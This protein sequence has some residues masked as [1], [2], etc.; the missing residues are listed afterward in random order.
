MEYKAHR[1]SIKVLERI[2][3]GYTVEDSK[4]SCDNDGIDVVVY[5]EKEKRIRID[6]WYDYGGEI[7]ENLDMSVKEFCDALGIVPEDILSDKEK[8][9]F[10]SAANIS[11]TFF[12]YG[13]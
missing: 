5:G 6:A 8:I 12:N 4:E 7:E 11:G 9:I 10:E 3:T 2:V 1:E 13:D